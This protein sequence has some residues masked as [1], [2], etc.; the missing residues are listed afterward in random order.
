[1]TAFDTVVSILD[2]FYDKRNYTEIVF[3]QA[4]QHGSDS[5][6][7]LNLKFHMKT[8]G[9]SDFNWQLMF[10]VSFEFLIEIAPFQT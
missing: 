7:H 8:A 1:M 5:R 10:R 6:A 4:F 2:I 9:E 3:C